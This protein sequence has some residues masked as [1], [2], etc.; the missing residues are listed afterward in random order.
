MKRPEVSPNELA[1]RRQASND[2]ETSNLLDMLVELEQYDLIPDE[3]GG[4]ICQGVALA[5]SL[6]QAQPRWANHS[7][8]FK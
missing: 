8:V 3:Q 6:T 5:R 4:S 2:Q 7:G 1:Y